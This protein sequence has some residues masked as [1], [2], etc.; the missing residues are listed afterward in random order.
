M[1]LE[2][3][4]LNR[5]AIRDALEF[6]A[7]HRQEIAKAAE[8]ASSSSTK[9]VLDQAERARAELID[10]AERAGKLGRGSAQRQNAHNVQAQVEYVR[11]AV[12]PLDVDQLSRELA[13]VLRSDAT[14]GA[15]LV[16]TEIVQEQA[17]LRAARKKRLAPNHALAQRLL[18]QARRTLDDARAGREDLESPRPNRNS[19][20]ADLFGQAAPEGDSQT[21][22]DA[23]AGDGHPGVDDL[24]A[25][26]REEGERTRETLREEGKRTRET[27]EGAAKSKGRTNLL[28]GLGALLISLASLYLQVHEPPPPPRHA[29]KEPSSLRSQGPTAPPA[30]GPSSD[31]LRLGPPPKTPPGDAWGPVS[32]LPRAR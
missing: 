26:I 32:G 30:A 29:P 31:R 28:L 16:A 6:V 21:G 3:A 25:A 10:A 23:P 22:D 24:I 13:W 18:A 17:E 19:A 14:V 4:G 9:Q 11:R 7:A 12:A 15:K 27:I 20:G 2:M 1:T 8:A 5:R